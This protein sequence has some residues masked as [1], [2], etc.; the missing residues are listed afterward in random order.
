MCF[1]NRCALLEYQQGL[2]ISKGWLDVPVFFPH[3]Q[4]A[5]QVLLRKAGASCLVASEENITGSAPSVNTACYSARVNRSGA[6]ELE[7]REHLAQP[8]APA[9]CLFQLSYPHD[10]QGAHHYSTAGP[11]L[12]PARPQLK[13]TAG[14]RSDMPP[15][16]FP[17]AVPARRRSPQLDSQWKLACLNSTGPCIWNA[18]ITCIIP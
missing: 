10:I 1:A 11:H 18:T 14:V 2:A 6:H 7:L 17:G 4:V 13:L 3:I 15:T 9:G 16:L 12:P 8:L 5:T